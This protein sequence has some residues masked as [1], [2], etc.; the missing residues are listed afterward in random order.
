MNKKEF[1]KKIAFNTGLSQNNTKIIIDAFLNLIV[2]EIVKGNSIQLMRFGRWFP[3]IVPTRN[4]YSISQKQI[5][6]KEQRRTVSFKPS[7][8]LMH[9]T[10]KSSDNIAIVIND[11][12]ILQNSK[13]SLNNKK[14]SI[15]KRD[16]ER[17]VILPITN[18][19]SGNR[20]EKITELNIGQRMN[21]KQTIET[22]KFEFEGKTQ[23]YQTES[24]D[25]ENYYYPELLIPFV[26]TPI[27][28]YRTE[29]YSTVG[30][31][32][33]ILVKALNILRQTEPDIEII[34][35][36]SIPIHNRTYGYKPDI[37]IIWEKK[38]LFIDV[39]IDE[40]YDI[41][42]RKPIHYK[43]CS[44]N[45]RNAYLIDNGWNVIRI[46]EKQIV[47][48]CSNV[49]DFIK[50][51]ICQLTGDTRFFIKQNITNINR[52]KYSEAEKWAENGYR[53]EYLGIEKISLLQNGSVIEPEEEYLSHDPTLPMDHF[54]KPSDDIIE[55][56][57]DK[58][59]ESIILECQKAKY[60]IFTLKSKFYD[61]VALSDNIIFSME[62]RQYGIKLY[63]I[64]EKK[65]IFIQ[66]QTIDSFHSSDDIIKQTLDENEDWNILLREAIL[67]SNPVEILYNTN[68]H[69]YPILRTEI[70]LTPWY[71]N[72]YT[73]ENRKKFP[74]EELLKAANLH[75]FEDLV[76]IN[77][78]S[79]FTAYCTYRR[80][81]RTFNIT[82]I[83]SGRIFNCHKNPYK[84]KINDI[85][86]VLEKGYA[87]MAV[88]MYY[89]L[90]K[91]EQLDLYNLCNLA[92]ASIM[93]DKIEDALKIYMSIPK[94]QKM[95]HSERSWHET[96]I[97]DIKYFI[98]KDIYKDKFNKILLELEKRGW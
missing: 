66:F 72:W 14:S 43:G 76:K 62:N 40:P 20:I 95:M 5:Y 21:R 32:E 29:R 38:N 98:S 87:D 59:R 74:I 57:Y 41:V 44:D 45:L 49:V 6:K 85:W 30:V 60:I 24:V 65:D 2:H 71:Y 89:S 93:Q 28:K 61:Y 42:S 8:F 11:K 47:D 58:I 75:K 7:P 68:E 90:P 88:R 39:E 10:I 53:E 70:Y 97:E 67:N 22:G 79:H 33:P 3:K 13:Y 4:Y 64:I 48:E 31:V 84:I 81:I 46:A 82:R 92:N 18:I 78:I 16:N 35:N 56:R 12:S 54:V 91:H 96:C 37:A 36:I 51:C 94:E 1:I 15:P 55:D 19:K 34:Q 9:N 52:W 83:K 63:D 26:N 50:L 23:Y 17:K 25:T 80:D 86:N 73:E 69:E 27:L 77:K